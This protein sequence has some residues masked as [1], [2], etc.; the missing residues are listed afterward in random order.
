MKIEAPLTL[1]PMRVQPEWLD[2]NGHMNVA[3]YVKIFDDALEDVWEG[4][5]MGQKYIDEQNKSGF[6]LEMH[7]CY[8]R[9]LRENDP[10]KITFQLLAHDDKKMH[11]IM[12]MFHDEKNYLAATCEQIAI[13]V[14][15]AV[16]RTAPYPDWLQKNIRQVMAAHQSMPR[17]EQVGRIIK[18]KPKS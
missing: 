5:G 6:T 1:P 8:L 12:S 11:F 10:I 16:R 9:E 7:I 3:F 18:L 4:L 14:D 15:M 2:Y 17:P 13:H